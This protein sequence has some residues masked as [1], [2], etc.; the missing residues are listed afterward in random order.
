[1]NIEKNHAQG[2][3]A[4]SVPVDLRDNAPNPQANTGDRLVG[5]AAFFR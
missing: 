3:V 5:L 1:M 2:E 4:H